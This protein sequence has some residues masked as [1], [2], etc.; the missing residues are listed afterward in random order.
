MKREISNY[1]SYYITESGEVFHNE[2]KLKTFNCGAYK[3]ISLCKNGIIVKHYIHRLVAMMFLNNGLDFDLVV[4]HKNGDK[5]DNRVSNL[6]IVTQRENNLHAYR[7]KLHI[8]KI[9]SGENNYNAKLTYNDVLFIKNP[10]SEQLR[11]FGEFFLKR[12]LIRLERVSGLGSLFL[13]GGSTPRYI[14]IDTV[15]FECNFALCRKLT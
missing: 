12:T 13:H 2:K 1:P 6:E 14:V 4:N 8:P 11:D 9:Q 10:P 7:N 3:G 5:N 15:G